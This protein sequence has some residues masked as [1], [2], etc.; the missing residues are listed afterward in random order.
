MALPRF[1][2]SALSFDGQ[3]SLRELLSV[4]DSSTNLLLLNDLI[5]RALDRNG[6]VLERFALAFAFDL[7]DRGL[8]ELGLL[9]RA[10]RA[11][12]CAFG[13]TLGT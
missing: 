11:R 7:A 4:S 8:F 12:C 6:V 3:R 5:H 2:R 13:S 10:E 1:A 9:D